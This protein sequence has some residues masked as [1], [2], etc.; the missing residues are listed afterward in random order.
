MKTYESCPKKKRARFKTIISQYRHN[1]QR[2]LPPEKQY[3]TMC[4]TCARDGVVMLGSEF[5]QI[6]KSGLI[7]P[8]Q[9]HGVDIIPEIIEA[10][11]SAIPRANWHLGDFYQMLVEAQNGNNFNPGIVNCDL[12]V[13]PSQ[14]VQF[15]AKIL[16]LL[17]DEE[18]IMLIANFVL[19]ARQN[20]SSAE[21]I[22]GLFSR[23]PQFQYAKKRGWV[24]DNQVYVYNGTG[25][26]RSVLGTVVFC[27]G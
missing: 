17:S 18:E 9:F 15:V 23:Y 14:G 8:E 20:K 26:N 2:Q 21:E 1:F 6:L 13:M 10:N 11:R 22:F 4:A 5:D 25:T 7:Q 24:S 19:R 3:W 12:M 16:S 27:K